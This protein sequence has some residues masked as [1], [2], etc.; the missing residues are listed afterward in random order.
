MAL[1]KRTTSGQPGEWYYCLK[2]GKVE[3]GPECPAK[4][5]LGPYASREE[6]ARAIETARERDDQWRQDPRWNDEPD[7]EDGGEPDERRA[8]REDPGPW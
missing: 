2:H 3:E 8:D 1:F 6:A 5:R 4:D 7:R